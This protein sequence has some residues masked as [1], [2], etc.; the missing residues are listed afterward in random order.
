MVSGSL[1]A[2]TIAALTSAVASFHALAYGEAGCRGRRCGSRAG[3]WPSVPRAV[4]APVS[5]RCN[6]V[7]APSSITTCR[8]QPSCS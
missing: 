3:T 1:R 6:A 4:I 8:G 7:A 2:R 5:T